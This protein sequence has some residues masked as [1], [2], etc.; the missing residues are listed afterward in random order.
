M[1]EKWCSFSFDPS[2]HDVETFIRDVKA[3]GNQ[4]GH[5]NDSILNLIKA[6]MPT[7]IYGILYSITDLAD[8]IKLVKDIYAM[9]PDTCKTTAMT[10]MTTFST[11]QSKFATQLSFNL[12]SAH[13]PGFPNDGF[14]RYY[15]N[16]RFSNRRSRPY[17]PCITR[18]R[19]CFTNNYQDQF[20]R[21][22]NRY[23]GRGKFHSD[24]GNFTEVVEDHLKV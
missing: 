21:G 12:A 4:V 1:Y 7:E 5:R 9:K 17:M 10:S 23:Q 11:M 18:G 14:Y 15:D 3:T 19:G 24:R 6:C 8:Q 13:I 20:H 22:N 16:K 2:L